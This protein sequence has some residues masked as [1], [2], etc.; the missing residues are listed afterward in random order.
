MRFPRV[1]MMLFAVGLCLVSLNSRAAYFPPYGKCSGDKVL[2]FPPLTMEYQYGCNLTL[3]GARYDCCPAA[4]EESA[5]MARGC[6]L[7]IAAPDVCWETASYSYTIKTYTPTSQRC[8]NCT[9]SCPVTVTQVEY[10]GSNGCSG[11]VQTE[12]AHAS[13]TKCAG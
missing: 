9:G 11:Q 1:G 13:C 5:H 8:N 7:T 10:Q 2:C 3:A 4:V 6:S 12:T